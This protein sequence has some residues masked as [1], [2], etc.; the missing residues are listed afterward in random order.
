MM[1]QSSQQ[2][3]ANADSDTMFLLSLAPSL[4]KLDDRLKSR[5]KLSLM[6]VLSMSHCFIDLSEAS[7]H[8]YQRLIEILILL[9]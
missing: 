4:K 9:L 6:K 8:P 5:V 7:L 2:P 3:A 1:K